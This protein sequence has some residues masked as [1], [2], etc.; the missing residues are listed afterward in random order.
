MTK[1]ISTRAR[2]ETAVTGARVERRHQATLRQR[3]HFMPVK[4]MGQVIGHLLPRP[5]QIGPAGI[6][7]L[8]ARH[9]QSC[10]PG[11]V[12]RRRQGR[13]PLQGVKHTQAPQGEYLAGGQR[14]DCKD[15]TTQYAEPEPSQPLMGGEQIA[16]QPIR[17]KAQACRYQD[18]TAGPGEAP[19]PAHAA[20]R[21]C[22]H[23]LIDHRIEPWLG[24]L[25]LGRGKGPGGT[26]EFCL[27]R[28]GTG[29]A[30]NRAFHLSQSPTR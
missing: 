8:K 28:C 30:G 22:N 17:S 21:W 20:G 7:S 13:V 27:V 1:A 12:V 18:T 5:S 15:E 25:D 19:N 14:Y 10:A 11:I 16:D 4:Q 26:R 2:G 29:G 23:G 9:D 24:Y 6:D 3:H